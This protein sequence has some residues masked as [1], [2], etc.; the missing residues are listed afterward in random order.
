MVTFTLI[1][2]FYV[3]T[4]GSGNSNATT[5]VPNFVSEQECMDAGNKSKKLVD[6]TV[7]ELRYV[8]VKQTKAAM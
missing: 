4:M 6:G 3:G 8:C 1:L 7:K 5:T 2:F